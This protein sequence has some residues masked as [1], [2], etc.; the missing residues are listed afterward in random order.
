M[1]MGPWGTG[2]FEIVIILSSNPALNPPPTPR[3][4]QPSSRPLSAHHSTLLP[5]THHAHSLLAY[6]THN[7]HNAVAMQWGNWSYK[8]VDHVDNSDPEADADIDII[9]MDEKDTTTTTT[10]AQAAG[11]SSS[12]RR[13]TTSIIPL[14][15]T[16]TAVL[17][18][19]LFLFTPRPWLA[20]DH[21]A[22]VRHYGC[23]N[24]TADASAA[25]CRFDV[26]SYTWVHP[27][28][29]DQELMY[30]FLGAADWAWYADEDAAQPLPLADVA[31]GQREYVYVTWRYYTT[32]C[33]YSE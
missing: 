20:S 27:R 2:H 24:S 26:M 15:A 9:D 11:R 13:A 12:S 5:S 8:P 7:T 6:D 33:T 1:G 25:G 29:F 17:F 31:Q 21:P 28:C 30:D 19:V 16:L 32:H 18:F 22:R 10:R 23:G 3:T 4:A 14:A